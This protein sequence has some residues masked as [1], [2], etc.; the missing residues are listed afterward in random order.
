MD[1][2][3][4]DR[5]DPGDVAA[6][7]IGRRE[8][9]RRGAALGAALAVASPAVQALGRAAAFANTSPVPPSP[10][11]SPPPPPRRPDR[12]TAISYV[13]LVFRCNGET[14]RA[15]WEDGEGW[16]DVT[17]LGRWGSLPHCQVPEGWS[18]AT[19][20]PGPSFDAVPGAAGVIRVTPRY[21]AG[22]LYS[23]TFA[24]PVSCTFE[25]GIAKGGNPSRPQTGG[26]CARGEASGRAITF[27]AP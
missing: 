2:P 24:L 14:W 15:K 4:D 23:A 16:V 9:I 21:V 12:F 26:Y 22:E 13:G 27:T 19:G 10:P 7:E 8:L 3:S 1:D 20:L 11:P 6:V 25:R 5:H 17:T 18:S